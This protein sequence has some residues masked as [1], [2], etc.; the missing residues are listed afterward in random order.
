M[1]DET[2]ITEDFADWTKKIEISSR[3]DSEPVYIRARAFCAEYSL[4]Y[5]GD[6]WIRVPPKLPAAEETGDYWYYYDGI[7]EGG[8]TTSPLNVMIK[9]VPKKENEDPDKNPE[10]GD[11]FNVIVIYESIPVKYDS[12]GTRY[13]PWEIDWDDEKLEVVETT[14]PAAPGVPDV[15]EGGNN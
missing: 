11:R 10:I 3:E 5:S 8:K 15:T 6:G 2:E 4:E 1:G 14:S 7:L 13:Q 12:D 9:D